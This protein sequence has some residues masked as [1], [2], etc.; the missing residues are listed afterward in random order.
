MVQ[1]NFALKKHRFLSRLT[2]RQVAEAAGISLSTYGTYETG[3]QNRSVSL[4]GADK[5]V[6]IARTLGCSVEDIFAPENVRDSDNAD[7]ETDGEG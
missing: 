7:T 5:A 6:L 2:Q 1:E 3:F 4:P